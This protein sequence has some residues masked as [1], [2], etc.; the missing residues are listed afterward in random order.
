MFPWTWYLWRDAGGGLDGT[1]A[2]VPIDLV[3]LL[4]PVLAA[5]GATAAAAAALLR[6]RQAWAPAAASAV[7][8]G[9][10][11]TVGPWTAI[12]RPAPDEPLRVVF[13]NLALDNGS[14]T[15]ADLLDGLEADVLVTAETNGEQY[16]ALSERLGPPVVSGGDSAACSLP[17]AGECGALNVWTRLPA[18]VAGD[19]SAAGSA[20]GVRLEVETRSGTMVLYAV[21]PSPPSPRGGGVGRS[22][23]GEHRAV[24]AD[25]LAAARAEE[26]PVVLV[27]DLNLS[28]RQSGYR[29]FAQHLHDALRTDRTGPTSLK[30]FLR[31]LFLRIDHLFVSRDW[32]SADA[33]RVDLPGSDHRAVAV[34]VGPCP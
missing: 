8:F 1:W 26:E 29:D 14:T 5:L 3:S 22:S 10:V 7:V 18:A 20:R 19:Q 17:G 6:R 21:H 9:V 24:L 30:W 32:C 12:S 27:G 15:V 23:A 2:Q 11:A 33:R 34:E 13:A 31:P 25:L 4:L 16:T 28:D